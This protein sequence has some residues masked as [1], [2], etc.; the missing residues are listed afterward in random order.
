M[1]MIASIRVGNALDGPILIERFE[2]IKRLFGEHGGAALR[3]H[4]AVL[5]RCVPFHGRPPRGRNLDRRGRV[6][7]P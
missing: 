7:P 2:N 4:V 6:F 1:D 5:H 3:R